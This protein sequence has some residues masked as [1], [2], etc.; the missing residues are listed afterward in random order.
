MGGSFYSLYEEPVEIRLGG[1]KAY[2]FRTNFGNRHPGSR[3]WAE[4]MVTMLMLGGGVNLA[5]LQR[6]DLRETRG[7]SFPEA[8]DVG[9]MTHFNVGTKNI[10]ERG[11]RR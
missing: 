3:V 8:G 9:R 5:G 1:G 7:A 10:S 4:H 11:G 2:S 6:P